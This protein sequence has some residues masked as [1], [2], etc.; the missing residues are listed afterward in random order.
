MLYGIVA[1]LAHD[2]GRV[3]MGLIPATQIERFFL[4]DDVPRAKCRC[5]GRARQAHARVMWRVG[6]QFV[7]LSVD[8]LDFVVFEEPQL[9]QSTVFVH[10]PSPPARACATI[11]RAPNSRSAFPVDGGQDFG[12]PLE[13][14]EQDQI[15]T[16][17]RRTSTGHD[18]LRPNNAVLI[19][20][21]A[22]PAVQRFPFLSL[23]RCEWSVVTSEC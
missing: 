20:A 15:G 16:C 7:K 22:T 6:R 12:P 10:V 5:Q 18:D 4:A 8:E 2:D 23:V 9:I 21:V 1:R 17:G 19:L 11:R 3:G 13:W 14:S